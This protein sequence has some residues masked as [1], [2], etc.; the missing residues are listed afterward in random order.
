MCELLETAR[1]AGPPYTLVLEYSHKTSSTPSSGKDTSYRIMTVQPCTA[2]TLHSRP[3]YV[4]IV[5]ASFSKTLLGLQFPVPPVGTLLW[6]LMSG[7]QVRP[8]P[9]VPSYPDSRCSS[10]HSREVLSRGK[11]QVFTKEAVQT[12]KRPGSV[13]E[14]YIMCSTR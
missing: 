12:F 8:R 14:L 2:W 7:S 6:D 5:P 13:S 3:L 1:Q 9:L 11:S 10:D 4:G